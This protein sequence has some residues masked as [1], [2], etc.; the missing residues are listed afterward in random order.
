MNEI[1][2]TNRKN[3]MAVLI[4]VI[5]LYAAAILGVLGGLAVGGMLQGILTIVCLAWLCLAGS[6]CWG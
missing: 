5:I 6:C 3:G 1:T 4:L 2:L